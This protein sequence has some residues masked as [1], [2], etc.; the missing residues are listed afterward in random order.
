MYGIKKLTTTWMGGARSQ[1]IRDFFEPEKI[2]E[3]PTLREAIEFCNKRN[4]YAKLNKHRF[5]YA[6]RLHPI[7]L[8]KELRKEE[9]K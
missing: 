5:P 1:L 4:A 7:E 2:F 8:T 3:L 9:L 6:E